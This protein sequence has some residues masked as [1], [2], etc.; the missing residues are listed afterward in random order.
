M[1]FPVEALRQLPLG[2]A[3][4]QKAD[5]FKRSIKVAGFIHFLLF[6]GENEM[7]ACVKIPVPGFQSRHHPRYA[8]F[9]AFRHSNNLPPDFRRGL[10]ALYK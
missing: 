4:E 8:H 5:L 9:S 2:D 10:V 6:S 1:L 3:S 7:A